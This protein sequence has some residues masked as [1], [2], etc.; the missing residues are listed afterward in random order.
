MNTTNTVVGAGLLAGTAVLAAA[1][2]GLSHLIVRSA[3][4]AGV[5]VGHNR[6]SNAAVQRQRK[7]LKGAKVDDAEKKGGGVAG[8]RRHVDRAVARV[9]EAELNQ[10]Q[11][12]FGVVSVGLGILTFIYPVVGLSCLAALWLGRKTGSVKHELK[13]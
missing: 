12:A 11:G 1:D 10:E 9:S 7:L 6:M 3:L 8:R 2:G 13:T 5:G 4:A